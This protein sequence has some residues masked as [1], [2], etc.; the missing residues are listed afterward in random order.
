MLLLF[1]TKVSKIRVSD[2]TD[3]ILIERHL[4]ALFL[5]KIV[6]NSVLYY[7]LCAIFEICS[8]RSNQH[9]LDSASPSSI[10]A[11]RNEVNILLR[12]EGHKYGSDLCTVPRIRAWQKGAV[13][14]LFI[15]HPIDCGPEGSQNQIIKL[16]YQCDLNFRTVAKM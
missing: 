4:L 13:D 5:V 15:L 9:W 2:T 16:T 14:E 8:G 6:S 3:S 11:G 1:T 7:T 10:V 12:S